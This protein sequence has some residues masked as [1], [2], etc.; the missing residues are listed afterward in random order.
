MNV[1]YILG[2]PIN[3]RIDIFFSLIGAALYI[4][5][6]ILVFQ[7]WNKGFHDHFDSD[8]SKYA[9]AKAGLSIVQGVL[10]IIDIFFTF[11]D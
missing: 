2:T 7:D 10:F 4:T 5:C 6:G 8:A 3:K 11:R 1:G 9:K